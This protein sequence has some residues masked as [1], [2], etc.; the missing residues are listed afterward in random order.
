MLSKGRERV[1]VELNRQFVD[2]YCIDTEAPSNWRAMRAT[3]ER[4][5]V[6]DKTEIETF[7]T[8]C[9]RT[10]TSG[11]MDGDSDLRST[12]DAARKV[13][14]K[15]RQR[16]TGCKNEDKVLWLFIWRHDSQE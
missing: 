14:V 12:L 1:S 3:N 9:W 10:E 11:P 16:H 15:F 6:S 2:S 4:V 8:N 13:A 5:E 7:C